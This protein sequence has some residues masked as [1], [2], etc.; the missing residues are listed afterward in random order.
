MPLLCR[1][2]N[3]LKVS[4]IITLAVYV[5][6]LLTGLISFSEAT[7]FTPAKFAESQSFCAAN[8]RPQP[9]HL[10]YPRTKGFITTVQHLRSAPHVRAVYD[11]TI[12]YQHGGE[13]HAAPA[14]WETLSV[15]ALS[16]PSPQAGVAGYRFHIH[17]RRF[18][19]EDLPRE[20]G[21]LAN[22]LEQRWVE[23]GVW[24]E[25]RKKEWETGHG[26]EST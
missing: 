12:A 20:D 5:L 10:L 26:K 17:V 18:L 4:F 24:L 8:L 2:A 1:T 14:M 7:R 22:W 9:Q 21:E 6:T 25:E 23:K 11:F 16:N 15:P 13:W 19:M 3:I